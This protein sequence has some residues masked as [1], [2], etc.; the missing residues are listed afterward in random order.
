MYRFAIVDDDDSILLL[1]EELF[2]T[3]FKDS[4]IKKYES[5]ENFLSTSSAKD[6]DLIVTD[7]SLPGIS[8]IEMS[9][10]IKQS[11]NI[12]ILILTGNTD[13]EFVRKIF[14][15]GVIDEYISKPIETHVFLERVNNL[16]T[17]SSKYVWLKDVNLNSKFKVFLPD[18]LFVKT[19]EKQKTLEIHTLDQ[20][21]FIRGNLNDFSDLLDSRF[22]KFSRNLLLNPKKIE[23][24]DYSDYSISFGKSK[25]VF[26]RNKFFELE[27][28]I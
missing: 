27:K 2:K 7:F 11:T 26:N 9:K 4:S 18:I 8:G 16:L 3:F 19:A 21:Y 24:L 10:L 25:L 28:F 14:V 12:P 13:S 5:A 15:E 17:Q 23:K 20:I 1:I 22:L 6:F